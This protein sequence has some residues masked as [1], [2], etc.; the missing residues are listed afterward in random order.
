MYIPQFQ[1]V[2]FTCVPI[3]HIIPLLIFFL[4]TFHILFLPISVIFANWIFRKSL[5][6]W[7]ILVYISIHIVSDDIDMQQV[8]EIKL[9]IK[10]S[11]R[12]TAPVEVKM[13]QI[14][15]NE[16][17]GEDLAGTSTGNYRNRNFFKHFSLII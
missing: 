2:S 9:A 5:I 4:F 14:K 10:L 11:A 3:F 12:R 6:Y 1:N 16:F 8:D 17:T 7:H 13:T 15:C